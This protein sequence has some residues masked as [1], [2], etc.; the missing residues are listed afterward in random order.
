MDFPEVPR[1]ATKLASVI[2]IAL[3][4][5]LGWR[6]VWAG[7]R[8]VDELAELAPGELVD[9]VRL[10][11]DERI[12]RWLTS[13]EERWG[14]RPGSQV[15]LFELLRSELPGTA[16]VDLV[17]ERREAALAFP[18]MAPLLFPR[19]LRLLESTGP[20]LPAATPSADPDLYRLEYASA[21]GGEPGDSYELVAEGT[22]YRLW[23]CRGVRTE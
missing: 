17:A 19:Q 8:L 14:L 6:A 18:H 21:V 16:I 23:H 4:F 10:S 3:L 20:G 13:H 11:E 7:S 1:R 9:G 5:F 15:E 2:G 12:H 22:D